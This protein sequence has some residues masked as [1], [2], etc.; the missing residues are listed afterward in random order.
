VCASC[1]KRF[2]GEFVEL[3]VA[4]FGPG[5][6]PKVLERMFEPFFTTKDVG[7]GSG[8][9]LATVH[10]IVHE[11][12]GH[13]IVES[14]LGAGSRFRVLL[15]IH[16]GDAPAARRGRP[17]GRRKAALSG[18]VLIVDDEKAVADFMRELLESWGLEATAMTNPLGVLERVAR[19]RYDFV[20]LDQ[21]M[22]GMTGASLAREIA[23]A[24]PGLPV[25]LYTGNSDRVDREELRAAGVRA[26][27]QK[28]VE[29]AALYET[30]STHLH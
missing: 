28:P 18:R 25:V 5:I 3:A 20:I 23:A 12:G 26:L 21:T 4:D 7:R 24:R 17:A 27:L 13:I 19:E 22:P 2:R 16:G 9:G 29:P 14:T 30:L 1:R 10:G 15:P 6:A 11:H 8:M